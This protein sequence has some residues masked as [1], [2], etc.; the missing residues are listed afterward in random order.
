MA[1]DLT[2]VFKFNR[3]GAET[4]S[5]WTSIRKF[6]SCLDKSLSKVNKNMNVILGLDPNRTG[7]PGLQWHSLCPIGAFYQ[8]LEDSHA[9]SDAI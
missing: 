5:L 7:T 3:V 6:D 2:S 9:N 1:M 4:R 8:I